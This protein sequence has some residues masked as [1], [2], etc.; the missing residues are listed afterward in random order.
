MLYETKFL[1]HNYAS[2]VLPFNSNNITF[3]FQSLS[4]SWNESD[5]YF[6]TK[7][8]ELSSEKQISI[9]QGFNLLKDRNSTLAIG[10]NLN[11]MET[12][13][14]ASAGSNGDGSNGLKPLKY[15][16]NGLDLGFYAS[17]RNVISFGAFIKNI[18]SPKVVKGSTASNYPRRMN[19][20]IG[21]KPT[22]DLSTNF[23]LERVLGTDASSFRF[24]LEYKLAKVFTLRSGIQMNP[25]RFGIGFS[26]NIKAIEI[27][28]GVL[29][30]SVLSTTN[31]I[32]IKVSFEN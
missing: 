14:A 29:T 12:S 11:I 17:L 30:H 27:S 21:Y 32:D 8:F 18:N 4:T 28:Y 5:S 20:G 31:A 23:V 1:E 10:Y 25:N 15:R 6:G 19:L 16:T 7:N 24:G 13:Q 26:L 22:I 9:S 2:F 3:S